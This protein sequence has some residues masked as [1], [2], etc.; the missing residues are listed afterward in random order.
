MGVDNM[1]RHQP[2][3][4]IM[5][6]R[7]FLKSLTALVGGFALPAVANA[8]MSRSNTKTLQHSPLAGFQYHQG[9]TLWPQF[10]VGQ[11]LQLT[12]ETDNRY[13]ERAVRVDWQGHKLGYLPRMDN[14]AVSQLL[15]RG[16]SLEA[17]ICKLTESNNPWDRI[18]VEVRWRV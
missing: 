8:S 11:S 13:D 9:E 17:V 7:E 4:N 5:S 14:A 12:R 3:G 1:K 2:K 15:D 6:R 16:E 10:A 18:A